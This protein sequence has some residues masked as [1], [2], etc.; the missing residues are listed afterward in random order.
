MANDTNSAMDNLFQAIDIIVGERLSG[1]K[2][3]RTIKVTIIE[4]NI[5]V[6]TNIKLTLS[7]ILEIGA[8]EL[9]ASFTKLII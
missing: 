7:T 9:D 5:T 2:Y 4:I 1:L 8:F 6:G 3:D